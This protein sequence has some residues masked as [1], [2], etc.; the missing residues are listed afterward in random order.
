MAKKIVKKILG[1][2]IYFA[3]IVLAAYLLVTFVVQRT[4]VDGQSMETTLYDKDNLIM[5]KLTYRFAEPERFDI[6]VFPYQYQ[7]NTFYIKRIIALPGEEVFIDE[8]GLIYVNGQVLAESYGKEI[9]KEAGMAISPIQLG[10]DE[11]FVLG[12]N[13][14]HSA[15]SRVEQVGLI[16]REDIVGRAIFRIYPFSRFGL[17]Q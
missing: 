9:I 16:K 1:I 2:V 8:N 13:R 3:A 10:E 5:D 12:D 11:Y 15:D 17:I 7:D 4:T 14:N 6:I